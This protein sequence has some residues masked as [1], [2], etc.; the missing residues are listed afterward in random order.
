MTFFYELLADG[1]VAV[2]LAYMAYVILGQLDGHFT[3]P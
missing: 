1:L 2:H 3:S